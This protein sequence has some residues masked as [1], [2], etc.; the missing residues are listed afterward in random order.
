V[1]IKKA[2][3][4]IR[5]NKKFLVTTHTNAEGDALGAE[6]AFYWLLRR[7]GKEVVLVNEDTVPAQYNFLPFFEWIRI[8]NKRSMRL[9]FDCLAV[10]DCSEL[11]R[12][13]EVYRLNTFGAEV[14]NI[15]HHISNTLFGDVNWVRPA[16]SSTCEMIYWLYKA[17]KVPLDH[18]VALLLYTGIMTDTGSFRYSNT[19]SAVHK[20][21]AELL[22]YGLD[23]PG[24]YRRVYEN[25]DFEY[26]RLFSRILPAMRRELQGKV[27]WF[28]IDKA[29]LRQPE[30]LGFDLSE[31][32]LNFARAVKG[33]EV[34]ALFKENLGNKDEVRVNLRSQGKVDVNKI[35]LQFGGGGHKTA[36]GITV[37]GKLD[38]VRKQVLKAI[39]QSLL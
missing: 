34:C 31:H 35:A 32:L 17:L 33:V 20:I 2:A 21:S 6:L 28:K 4:C 9:N 10:L 26:L 12:T 8:L 23:V 3:A 22:S 18:R 13:G 37:K 36:S 11:S 24:I 30:R 15:D 27:I 1:T 7:L 39:R 29:L 16:T 25:I 14:L 38:T 5:R 19:S